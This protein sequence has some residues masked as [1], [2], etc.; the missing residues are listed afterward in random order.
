MTL[1][2]TDTE[3]KI[4][5]VTLVIPTFNE[6]GNL[7]YV[8]PQIPQLVDEVIIVDGH[9]IDNTVREAAKLC[10]RAR[11]IYQEGKGKG[12]A[13]RTGFTQATGDIVVTMDAD[14]SMNPNE[15][16][17]FVEA[18]KNGYDF[19]KGSRFVRSGGTNDAPKH[20]LFGNWALAVVTNMLY[21][22]HYT[23]VTYGF[24]AISRQ[25]LQ[26]IKLRSWGF[27]IETEMAIK[28][29]KAGLKITEIPSFESPRIAG[30]AKLNSYRDGWLI[31]KTIVAERFR[32]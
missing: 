3:N 31:L 28:S 17:R 30:Q 24:N 18:L 2:S 12:N 19:A 22:S 11:I 1:A 27:S 5:K 23:D 7:S 29:Q 6:E 4:L 8:L 15:I 9:S 32:S 13:L 10:P 25:S 26:K 14:G 21:R 16:V 20:R